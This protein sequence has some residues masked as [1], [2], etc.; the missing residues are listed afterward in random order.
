MDSVSTMTSLSDE[1]DFK[2]TGT[3]KD[4]SFK[5]SA[6]DK[7]SSSFEFATLSDDMEYSDKESSTTL[8]AAIVRHTKT[9]SEIP[10]PFETI[11]AHM[12]EL[13]EHGIAK[14]QIFD[15]E[16]LIEQGDFT[17]VAITCDKLLS[18]HLKDR[19]DTHETVDE[20]LLVLGVSGVHYVRFKDIITRANSG[21]VL[22]KDAL[23]C[24]F[25]LTD[26]EL[27]MQA[28]GIV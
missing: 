3:E 2:N 16:D 9:V 13:W 20:A 15:V 12:S 1:L 6:K 5:K 10:A 17:Q 22:R 14:D 23:F 28:A 24:L 25:F 18:L 7:S 21:D 19:G 8:A 11:N 26:I 4:L 27:R